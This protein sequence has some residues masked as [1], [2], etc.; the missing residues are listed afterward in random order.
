MLF[1]SPYCSRFQNIFLNSVRTSL[2]RS[3][4]LGLSACFCV[5]K[6]FGLPK[7]IL[8]YSSKFS[9]SLFMA[10]PCVVLALPWL[11]LTLQSWRK[12]VQLSTKYA[13]DFIC[14][15]LFLLIVTI[16]KKEFITC[17]AVFIYLSEIRREPM[18][19]SSGG[20]G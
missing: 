11:T 13:V 9:I 19:L 7:G 17:I 15:R 16:F 4:T 6:V 14:L 12:T 18:K 20:E 1:C 5:V 8:L 2:Q 3:K 10:A